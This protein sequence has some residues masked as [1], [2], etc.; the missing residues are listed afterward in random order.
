MPTS[1]TL[2]LL[3]RAKQVIPGGVNSATRGLPFPFVPGHA[4]GAYLFDSADR[5]YLDYHAAFGPL[6]LGH[7]HPRVTASVVQAIAERAQDLVG[8]SVTEVEIA[9]AE[10]IVAHVPS[11]E[12]VLLC[13]TGSDAVES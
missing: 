12:M 5:P 6:V 1:E 11:A 4:R 13:S 8:I 10:K 2:D 7:N 3:A 9:L